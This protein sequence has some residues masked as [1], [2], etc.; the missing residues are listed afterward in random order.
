MFTFPAEKALSS[1][2][3]PLTASDEINFSKAGLFETVR[4]TAGLHR[5]VWVS[6]TDIFVDVHISNNSRKAVKKLDLSL[7]RDILYYRHV[8]K[9]PGSVYQKLTVDV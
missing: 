3:S 4:I 2:T 8:R 6:G 1:L 7:E 9:S 5:Q